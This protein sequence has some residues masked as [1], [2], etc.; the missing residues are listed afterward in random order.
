[1]NDRVGAG[2]VAA[3]PTRAA[4]PAAAAVATDES[5]DAGRARAGER[6]HT[7]LAG[8][9]LWSIASD[10]LGPDATPARVARE[11]HRLWQLNK[12]RIGT[13]DPDLIL[14]GTVLKLR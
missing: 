7:V 13:G 2:T 12:D 5:L 9:S 4:A 1:M 8:E 3:K 14:I 10:L 11:V 6:T